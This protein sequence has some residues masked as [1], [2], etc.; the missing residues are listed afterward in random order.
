MPQATPH[1]VVVFKLHVEDLGRRVLPICLNNCST[2]VFVLL[3][4]ECMY[5]YGT[6][7]CD[8][9]PVQKFY[10]FYYAYGLPFP[11]KNL[12]NLSLFAPCLQLKY[13]TH[14]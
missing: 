9:H 3:R 14:F 13:L 12:K 10:S 2:S 4:T 5:F 6:Y 1:N 11:C 7:S 8:S